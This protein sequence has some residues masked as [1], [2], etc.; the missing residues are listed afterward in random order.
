MSS[1][2]NYKNKC[3]ELCKNVEVKFKEAYEKRQQEECRHRPRKKLSFPVLACLINHRLSLDK[4]GE[5]IQATTPSQIAIF[6]PSFNR[7]AKEMS[8]C[9]TDLTYALSEPFLRT[10]QLFVPCINTIC[11]KIAVYEIVSLYEVLSSLP[12]HCIEYFFLL[13]CKLDVTP[14]KQ[15]LLLFAR[16]I[17]FVRFLC[18]GSSVDDNDLEIIVAANARPSCELVDS[19]EELDDSLAEESSGDALGSRL[20]YLC[21]FSTNI[22]SSTLSSCG[23]SVL[24]RNLKRLCLF[25]VQMLD[26][27]RAWDPSTIC[28]EVL[29]AI[30]NFEQL[31][32]LDIYFCRWVCYEGMSI[33]ANRLLEEPASPG[34]PR[35]MHRFSLTTI[36][37][38]G[39]EWCTFS[40]SCTVHRNCIES[41]RRL[42]ID[43]CIRLEELYRLRLNVSLS[44]NS[45]L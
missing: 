15:I 8:S 26:D 27:L 41:C 45:I 11:R 17:W 30:G 34:R 1:G 37:V 7:F 29:T 43:R 18:L 4:R 14:A 24:F 21:L 44:F 2:R 39:F 19:W 33:W 38:S 28:C 3:N 36:S 31:R 10:A 23:S 35:T 6:D 16:D 25:D 22:S 32:Q 42:G 13:S 20:E 5:K 40:P 9:R 12:I